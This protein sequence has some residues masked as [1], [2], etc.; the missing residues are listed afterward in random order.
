M[1]SKYNPVQE[2]MTFA[3]QVKEY[4]GFI[5]VLGIGG[6]YHIKSISERFPEAHILAIENSADDL[7]FLKN[8]Q[9]IQDLQ[10][11]K[12]ITF[13]AC[14]EKSEI[15]R[16]LTS[17][18]IPAFHGNLTI[19]VHRAWAEHLPE[20]TKLLTK[21]IQQILSEISADYS[22]QAH[23]GKIWQHNIMQNLYFF[24]EYSKKHSEE[25]SIIIKSYFAVI[26]LPSKL[27]LTS[28]S[29]R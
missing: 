16:L 7:N 3:G 29:G 6:G 28:Y 12:K 10:K 2:G 27:S 9:C 19:C 25:L 15:S 11:N 20:K 24:S 1:H 14:E 4:S 17:L 13:A 5:V 8:I 23:F 22:V 18:Y 26:I 21:Y